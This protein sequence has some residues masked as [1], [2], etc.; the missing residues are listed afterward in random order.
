MRFEIPWDYCVSKRD[1]IVLRRTR[2]KVVPRTTDRW[3]LALRS[4]NLKAASQAQHPPFAFDVRVDFYLYPPSRNQ[5]DPHNYMEVVL[6]GLEGVAY[7]NDSQGKQGSWHLIEYDRSNPRMIID[8][9]PAQP[10]LEV[11]PPPASH[12]P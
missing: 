2:G 12:L 3:K 4:I 10:L 1:K 7:L 11:P 5:R 6:D 9:S 8:V